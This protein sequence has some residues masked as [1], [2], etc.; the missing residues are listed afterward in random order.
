[1]NWSQLTVLVTGGTGSFGKKFVE[2]VLERYRPK[3]LIVL[4]RDELKQRHGLD[5]LEPLNWNEDLFG[6][7]QA[8]P[9][10]FARL[11]RGQPEPDLDLGEL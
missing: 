5:D 10:Q 11:V 3:K 1:M 7:P 8:V 4:S 6:P 9:V 2:I